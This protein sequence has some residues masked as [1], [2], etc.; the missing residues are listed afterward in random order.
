[1]FIL[2]GFFVIAIYNLLNDESCLL[3]ERYDC[4]KSQ[5]KQVASIFDFL[6]LSELLLCCGIVIFASVL[7]VSIGM[8][9]GML[10]SPLVALVKPELVP[11]SILAMGLFVAFSGAWRERSNISM[12]ELKLGVVGRVIGSIMAFGML[13]IIPDVESFFIIFGVIMLIAISMTAFGNKIPFSDKSLLNLSVVSGVIGSIT[14]VGAPPMALIYHDKDPAIVRPTLNAFFFS[15]SA[16]GLI[17]LGLSG[18]ISVQ[19]FLAAV[20]FIPA[21]FVGILISEPFKKLPSALMSKLLLSLSAIAS[22]LL[23]LRGL[24]W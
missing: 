19:D 16:L 12:N 18:W 17:S 2:T 4:V 13:L 11:G 1:M 3:S 15:G 22:I 8:G 20:L 21:M 6:T 24:V 9:F 14:A 5:G 7:Q 10:A 23:I